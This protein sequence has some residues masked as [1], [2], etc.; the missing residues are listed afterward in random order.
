MVP[1]SDISTYTKTVLKMSRIK[2]ALQYREITKMQREG[3][4]PLIVVGAGLAAVA[5]FLAGSFVLIMH[6][7]L[8]VDETFHYPQIKNFLE[9]NFHLSPHLAMLP[10]YHYAVSAIAFILG[11]KS[12]A[13][14]RFISFC[15]AIMSIT[16]FYILA[17]YLQEQDSPSKTF[18]YVFFPLLYPFFF[19]IYTEALSILLVF[20][21]TYLAL[22]KRYYLAGMVGILSC[23]VRQDNI[24]WV[25]FMFLLLVL[26][27]LCA[28][29]SIAVTRGGKRLGVSMA[30]I[31]TIA[32]N[33][34]IYLGAFTLFAAF[35]FVNKGVA[36]AD[37]EMNRGI[38]L[39]NVYFLLFTFFFMFLPMNLGNAPKIVALVRRRKL[40]SVYIVGLFLLFLATFTI[41][42]PYNTEPWAQ[43]FLS[44]QILTFFN[45]DVLLKALF[46]LPVLYSVLSLLTTRLYERKYYLIFPMSIIFLAP[47]WPVDP[48]YYLIPFVLFLLFKEDDPKPIRYFTYLMY[49]GLSGYFFLSIVS[50]KYFF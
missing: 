32:V 42:H 4:L 13:S 7:K 8:N 23:L 26:D 25:G 24:V 22:E 37:V 49:V 38:H 19:L 45:R 35:V 33:G 27:V 40:V 6:M 44:N 31:R 41:D 50:Y 21:A 3:K 34:A 15:I 46:F 39:G 12:V 36:V 10:G 28:D 1:E 11:A 48:R 17:C 5:V 43:W 14:I 47:H 29:N 9:F 30:T 16:L 2:G 20:L 18:Q